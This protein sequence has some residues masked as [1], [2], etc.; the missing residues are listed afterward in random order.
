MS[1]KDIGRVVR[2]ARLAAL[3]L[4]VLA[5]A[6]PGFAA[7]GGGMDPGYVPG[8]LVIKL[9]AGFGPSDAASVAALAGAVVKKP[10]PV[11]GFYL[12]A[13]KDTA[14]TVVQMRD[15]LR[16]DARVSSSDPNYRCKL[17][18]EPNDPYYAQQ[19]NLV[20]VNMPEAWEPIH[21]RDASGIRVAVVDACVR[22]DHPDLAGRIVA[23]YDVA[24]DDEDTNPPE[25]ARPWSEH[26][27]MVAGIIGA[28]TDNRIGIAGVCWDGVQIVPVKVYEDSNNTVYG[29]GDDFVAGLDEAL[30]RNAN[31]VNMSM[32]FAVTF[33]LLREK[34]EELAD[35]GIILVAA[36]GNGS[37]NVSYPA[38]YP[39]VI[40]VSS[41][42]SDKE[43]SEFSNRGPQVDVAAPGED[44]TS[45]G[46]DSTVT[47]IAYYLTE[48]GTSFA[49]PHVAGAA[50]ILLANG[51][52][53][54]S[55]LDAI[56]ATA[57]QQGTEIPNDEYGYGILDVGAA[58]LYQSFNVIID[59]PQNGDSLST[60]YPPVRISLN[61][62]A[63]G[64][65][66]V[67][68]D[69]ETAISGGQIANAKVSHYSAP[70]T[71]GQ[72][73]FTWPFT[74]GTHRINVTA[75]P[76]YSA[77]ETVTVRSTFTVAPRTLPPGMYMFS[78]PFAT[79]GSQTGLGD[80]VAGADGSPLFVYR[81]ARWDPEVAAYK[82][83]NYPGI[84][85]ETGASLQPPNVRAG[86]NALPADGVVST[87]LPRGV[88]Y[89]L[90][91]RQSASLISSTYVD[92]SKT[93]AIEL[94]HGWNQIGNPF[95][96]PVGWGS[97]LV[98]YL[99]ETVSI[100]QAV[101]RGWIGSSL[102]RYES[103]SYRADSAPNGLLEPWKGY[104]VYVKVPPTGGA[105]ADPNAAT[106]KV[107][108]FI[109]PL[110]GALAGSLP[111]TPAGVSGSGVS[112]TAGSASGSVRGTLAAGK[113]S[114]G[115]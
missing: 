3:L 73:A 93:Y 90:D 52:P 48:S 36:A 34:I 42:N 22:T 32:E 74:T 49:A 107:T 109:P 7:G 106:A 80:V 71:S 86:E 89:W 11:E 13:A 102:Y 97:V 31:V 4:A 47:P 64:T 23:G 68:V 28:V 91:L 43:I 99:N 84:P 85:N 108:L 21:I 76:V 35:A 114:S 63:I 87:T 66:Q 98:R 60:T 55:V 61:G 72:L 70:T 10:L 103:G 105:P 44:V 17:S 96:F 39:E 46:V 50:A 104:W 5:A 65:V 82:L 30:K 59:R 110:Q 2:V 24:D 79:A 20:L 112:N 77:T 14:T 111:L 62:V 8:E 15:A 88:G 92:D 53:A 37:G 38:A 100:T 29:S 40:C 75:S 19:W 6:S 57:Q 81:Q 12:L 45:T 67:L 78:L 101:S 9:R 1:S 95:P 56:Q 51:R 54:S 18:A 94:K 58:L 27:T 41:V 25:E 69:G 33:D 113:G 83:Y 115:R 26:G 16:T